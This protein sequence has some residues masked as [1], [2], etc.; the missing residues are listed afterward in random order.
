MLGWAP[1]FK[2]G[3][4]A[5]GSSRTPSNNF[6]YWDTLN[7]PNWHTASLKGLYRRSYY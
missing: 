5:L 7:L 1:F 3:K 6:A 2:F 4:N